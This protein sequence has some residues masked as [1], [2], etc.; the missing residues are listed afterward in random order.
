[1]KSCISDTK[2]Y[3][4]IFTQNLTLDFIFG[5]RGFDTR[6]NIFYTP[7][8]EIIFHAAGAGI[9]Y[10]RHT[11][12]QSFY[13]EHNDDIICLALNPSPKALNVVATGQ[14]GKNAPIHLWDI[15]TKQTLSI[16]QGAHSVGV[17][18][19]DFNHN[20]KLLVSVGLDSKNSITV[21]R[22]AEGMRLICFI[23]PQSYTCLYVCMY[24]CLS[25]SVCL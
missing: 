10:D 5:Y 20:G 11:K 15:Q 6:Q 13:L 14:I 17:C 25:L 3:S 22:W 19:V 9:V 2:T 18:S 4:F 23:I 7:N 21:W 8:G 12:K 16:L 1:M 24:V